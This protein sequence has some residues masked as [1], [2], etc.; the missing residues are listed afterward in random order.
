MY[1]CLSYRVY[2]RLLDRLCVLHGRGA[3]VYLYMY[4]LELDTWIVVTFI[5]VFVLHV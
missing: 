1:V 2:I 3:W 5:H 4:V